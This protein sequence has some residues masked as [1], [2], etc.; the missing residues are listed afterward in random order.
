[1]F[2]IILKPLALFP[3]LLSVK[4]YISFSVNIVRLLINLI[5]P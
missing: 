2:G 5:K 4:C 3:L 1:M